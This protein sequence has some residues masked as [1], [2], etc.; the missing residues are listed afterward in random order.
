MNNCLWSSALAAA[1]VLG[2]VLTGVPQLSAA[3][4]SVDS[5]SKSSSAKEALAQ[6]NSLIGGW[7][8]V[9]QPRRGSAAGSWQ[10]A[11]EWVWD[12]SQPTPAIRYVV[13]DGKLIKTARFTFDE[14][15]GLFHAAVT[16]P[17]GDDPRLRGQVRRRS[18]PPGIKPRR[19]ARNP[20]HHRHAAQ[21]EAAR[22][23]C[24]RKNA[25]RPALR[26]ASPKSA[27]PARERVWPS[28]GPTARNA[29]SPAARG[30]FRSATRARRTTSAARAASRPSTRTPKKSSPNTAPHCQAEPG[31]Q[32]TLR[33]PD[34]CWRSSGHRFRAIDA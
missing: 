6:F 34:E 23:S 33:Q 15:T 11:A 19:E 20:P 10:E 3:P 30:R 8:G 16:L 5:H 27:T 24:S 4:R 2:S 25:P 32:V 22:S 31:R 12:F 29:S 21:R 17:D 1:I 28:K 14:P 9:G 7:R 26:H 18:A 13:T